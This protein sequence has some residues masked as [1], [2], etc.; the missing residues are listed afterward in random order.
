LNAKVWFI[1][2]NLTNIGS[3]DGNAIVIPDKSVS[4]RHA[5]IKVQ[6]ARFELADYGS[7]N[8]VMVN[9]QRITKQFLKSGD[10][11]SI[12]AVEMEFTLK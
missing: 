11:L 8:G 3:A 6:D 9:G 2:E 12:G 5:G 7:T 10:V 4:K 1:K